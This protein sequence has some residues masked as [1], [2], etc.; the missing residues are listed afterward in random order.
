[1]AGQDPP[2][3]VVGAGAPRPARRFNSEDPSTYGPLVWIAAMA[4]LFGPAILAFLVRWL[5]T[6]GPWYPRVELWVVAIVIALAA[7]LELNEA[8]RLRKQIVPGVVRPGQRER[9]KL[10]NAIG[11]G[12]IALA[13]AA[14]AA[15]FEPWLGA[16]IV[17]LAA[18][19]WA[20]CAVTP[21]RHLRSGYV[22][23][24]ACP[25]DGAYAF[26]SDLSTI[27][28]Y[29][30]Q[31]TVVPPLPERTEVGAVRHVR[32]T[33]GNGSVVDAD[34][35]V[36]ELIPGR[37]IT[38]GVVGLGRRNVSTFEVE[39]LPDAGSRVSY[40]FRGSRTISEMVLLD[41]FDKKGGL[42][43]IAKLHRETADRL[44]RLLDART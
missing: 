11:L 19:W 22:L 12:L 43:R 42:Q 17:M 34:E 23:Q 26:V 44:K 21:Q 40:L 33:A 24:T 7:G 1:M 8:E 37:R 41:G 32:A 14:A 16:G 35:V 25:P 27:T 9:V 38:F 13:E 5:T 30:P 3:F 39:P 28:Q 6:S 2:D 15:S 4:V 29:L 31:E 36:T 18:G 10:R 20:F